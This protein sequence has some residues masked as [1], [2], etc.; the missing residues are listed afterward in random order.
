MDSSVLAFTL[1]LVKTFVSNHRSEDYLS[2]PCSLN[3]LV[4]I[5]R[6]LSSN[7]ALQEYADRVSYWDAE[8]CAKNPDAIDIIIALG[9]R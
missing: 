1:Q 4:Y 9:I 3:F 2:S 8:F 5:D 6:I 7:P